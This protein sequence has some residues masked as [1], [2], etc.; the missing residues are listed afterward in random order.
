MNYII[1]WLHLYSIHFGTIVASLITLDVVK[2]GLPDSFKDSKKKVASAIL[3][4]AVTALFS[5]HA[6]NHY[7]THYTKEITKELK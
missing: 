7:L 5:S 3:I 1:E 4:S 6:Q 2:K